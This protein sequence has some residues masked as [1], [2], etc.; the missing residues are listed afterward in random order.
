MEQKIFLTTP[1]LHT[2]KLHT[3]CKII[4]LLELTDKVNYLD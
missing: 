1:V 3:L 2:G 4:T